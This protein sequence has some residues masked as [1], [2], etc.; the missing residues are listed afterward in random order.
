MNREEIK[1]FL[2]KKFI[3]KD[4]V[5]DEKELFAFYVSKEFEESGGNDKYALIGVGPFYF[6]KQT[7]EK[8]KLGAMEFHTNYINKDIFRIKGGNITEPSLEDTI[9]SIKSRKH[10]N[11]DE[12]EIIMNKMKIDFLRVSISSLDCIHEIIESPEPND[13]DKFKQIFEKSELEFVHESPNKII[14][15][16]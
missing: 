10:I 12:F 7:Q 6:N 11:G 2:G 1:T 13:I 5:E 9:K 3:I 14:L 15:K 4:I 8:R 16:N